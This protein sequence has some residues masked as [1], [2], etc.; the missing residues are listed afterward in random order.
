MILEG[1]FYFFLTKLYWL[2]LSITTI[3]IPSYV[4]INISN[5]NNNKWK[6][7]IK[8]GQ[9]SGT[10]VTAGRYFAI[11]RKIYFCSYQRVASLHYLQV[12]AMNNH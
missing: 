11:Q 8:T 6:T 2:K 7:Q 4:H 5:T 3:N 12:R 1:M 9:Y 10:H